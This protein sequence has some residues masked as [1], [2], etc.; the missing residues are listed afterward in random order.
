MR[1]V[2]IIYGLHDMHLNPLHLFASSGTEQG[3]Y[4][5]ENLILDPKKLPVVVLLFPFH[6]FLLLPSLSSHFRISFELVTLRTYYTLLQSN[7]STE[8]IKILY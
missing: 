6:H 3:A 5:A 1:Y 8:N 4:Q 2:W 7:N